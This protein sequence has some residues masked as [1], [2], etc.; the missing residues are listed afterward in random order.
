MRRLSEVFGEISDVDTKDCL[1]P[2][3]QK[4]GRDVLAY[5]TLIIF[6]KM[7]HLLTVKG[8]V[9]FPL[10][11]FPSSSHFDSCVCIFQRKC[12]RLIK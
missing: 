9:L 5:P 10:L 11:I 2:T 8:Y 1:M 12:I 6:Q 7:F 3:F 4:V